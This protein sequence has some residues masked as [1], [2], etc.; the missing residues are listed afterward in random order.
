MWMKIVEEDLEIKNCL[1]LY[2]WLTRLSVRQSRR[3]H[4]YPFDLWKVVRVRFRLTDAVEKLY[5]ESQLTQPLRLGLRSW[6]G[7]CERRI[8]QDGR[9]KQLSTAKKSTCGFSSCPFTVFGEKS[10]FSFE[11]M[12]LSR[13]ELGFSPTNQKLFEEDILKAWRHYLADRSLTGSGRT[14]LYTARELMM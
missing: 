12:Q 4:R 2:V 6:S 3:G 1:R 13:K 10:L 14:T 5:V 8:P 11:R 7:H 9:M